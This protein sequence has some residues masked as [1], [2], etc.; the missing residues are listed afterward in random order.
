MKKLDQFEFI[1]KCKEVHKNK[2]DYSLVEYKN[3]GS[4]IDI[5]CN[6]HGLFQQ[7]AKNHKEGQGCSRCYG[8]K[9]LT[10][11]EFIKKCNSKIYDY[12]LLK[13]PIRIRE[14]IRIIDK[15][16]GIIYNQ[17]ASHHLNVISPKKI[18]INSLIDRLNK[19][20]NF[21]YTYIGEKVVGQTSKIKL[22]DNLTKDEFFYRVDRHL[23]G[24]CPN[25]VTVNYFKIKS[26]K[27]HD[28][29]YDYSLILKINNNSDKVKIVCPYHGIFNQSVSNHM[30]L[31]DGCP[32]C[33]GRGK[34][35]NELLISEFKKTHLDKYNYS[36]VEFTGVSNKI[37][38]IC[39]THGTF[40]QT[41]YH[42]LKGQG[43]KLCK[44]NSIGEEYIKLH[45]EEME[46][47]YIQQH[48]FDTCRYINKLSF[49]F[50]LPEYN[51]CI[52]FDRI[53]HFKEVK[54]FGGKKEFNN[55]LKRDECKNKWC[56]ENNIKLIRIKYDQISEI[57]E[58]LN[59]ELSHKNKSLVN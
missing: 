2:Y 27:L 58:I 46:I 31:K 25:K 43:C 39:N 9:N 52:E 36:L 13:S 22:I 7:I 40:E 17:F 45:L 30:N 50:Y 57:G 23:K 34:W 11:E 12:S 20:H 38:V 51:I 44:S 16:T 3:I 28:N 59:I 32:V 33:T 19:I 49:D 21:K 29:K 18:E 4:K 1:K 48:G 42:H 15:N 35:N 5:L 47:K 55:T 37:K 56:L 24:M 54:Q 8:N 14:I 6:L 10:K 41:I 26:S 53:Q